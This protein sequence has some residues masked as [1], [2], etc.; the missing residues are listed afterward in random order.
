VNCTGVLIES[1]LKSVERYLE[2][3]GGAM[4]PK[5][6]SCPDVPRNKDGI[7]A[8]AFDIAQKQEQKQ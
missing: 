7:P 4:E 8:T 3:V 6:E 1:A 5:Q 2:D